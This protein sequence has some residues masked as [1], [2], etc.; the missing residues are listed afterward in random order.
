MSSTNAGAST[1]TNML[2]TTT[3]TSTKDPTANSSITT[4]PSIT[5]TSTPVTLTT[6]N[7][8]IST[9][10][11]V[12]K[13]LA[14][15]T[16]NPTTPITLDSLKINN[17]NHQI[18]KLT[19]PSTNKIT[20]QS[21]PSILST[22]L[23]KNIL[24]NNNNNNNNINNNGSINSTMANQASSP[25]QNNNIFNLFKN[26]VDESTHPIVTTLMTN[27]PSINKINPNS[28]TPKVIN[29]Q[30]TFISNINL[31]SLSPISFDNL[32][33]QSQHINN[34][35]N[36]SNSNN[37]SNNNKK[38]TVLQPIKI[39]LP[40]NHQD[41]VLTNQLKN[42]NSSTSSPHL[43]SHLIQSLQPIRL[44]QTTNTP[45]TTTT[46]T[47]TNNSPLP[48]PSQLQQQQQPINNNS[49]SSSPL[50]PNIIRKTQKKLDGSPSI[51]DRPSLN[52]QPLPTTVSNLIKN[53]A[54]QIYELSRQ[55]HED[56]NKPTLITLQHQKINHISL[57]QQHPLPSQPQPQSQIQQ[58]SLQT[59][60]SYSS[61]SSPST[62]SLLPSQ[63]TIVN[64][65]DSTQD[66]SNN[67]KRRK[68][69]LKKQMDSEPLIN[70]ELINP[71]TNNRYLNENNKL[72]N[73]NIKLNKLV[74]YTTNIKTNTVKLEDNIV[75]KE[76]E[77]EDDEEEPPV[78]KIHHENQDESAIILNDD[79][80]DDEELTESSENIHESANEQEDLSLILDDETVEKLSKEFSY[81]TKDGIKWVSRRRMRAIP[82]NYNYNN[83]LSSQNN[84]FKKY[85]DLSQIDTS[86]CSTR[87][88]QI[89]HKDL[90]DNLNEWRFHLVLSQLNNL[91][92]FENES[93]N[94]I[95]DV[96]Q[97]I[98][99][100]N[101]SLMNGINTLK[102]NESIKANSQRHNFVNEQL[103]ETQFIINKLVEHKEK[104]KNYL[105]LKTTNKNS[106]ETNNNLDDDKSNANLNIT[107]N[108][109]SKHFNS[110]KSYN[111]LK[112]K[113]TT[114]T[115]AATTK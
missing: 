16:T 84:H 56:S 26:K 80:D 95:K 78:K 60:A 81:T 24:N 37:N 30:N 38:L 77:E 92:E 40:E 86:S 52:D 33:T 101:F 17:S 70:F 11:N 89:K 76:I 41:L 53:K 114:S 107:P 25:S 48:Q 94:L 74:N 97:L 58:T 91:I 54:Q 7:L 90:N 112:N 105:I 93:M 98:N 47:L 106:I 2:T 69:E 83:R 32:Q 99:Q 39:P 15:S 5:T 57:S 96:E 85:S 10:H 46:V 88:N 27:V 43:V 4:T 23:V 111:H 64:L 35:N 51:S 82:A 36:I 6:K 45:T 19:T 8:I 100:N 66:S 75:K 49:P 73:Q 87:P 67:R 29:N 34:N 79:D 115:A 14:N 63:T 20:L 113:T 3:T 68:Q 55:N 13:L 65:I 62:T 108:S 103:C 72:L 71:L 22:N 31:K 28:T 102:I 9:N 61:S 44:I 110:K 59:S 1:A 21:V 109:R 18:R 12:S 104:F 50:K 42:D